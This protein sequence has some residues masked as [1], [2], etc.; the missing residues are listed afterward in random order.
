MPKLYQFYA[1][2]PDLCQMPEAP[3]KTRNAR[4][5]PNR[6]YLA[7]WARL[8]LCQNAQ[9]MPLGQSEFQWV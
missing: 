6:E 2:M 4:F 1:K 8:G 7:Q 9:F 3:V 5:W